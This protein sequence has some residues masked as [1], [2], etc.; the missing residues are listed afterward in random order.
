[1]SQPLSNFLSV[2]KNC[3]GKST[4]EIIHL[5]NGIRF[6][7]HNCGKTEETIFNNVEKSQLQEAFPGVPIIEGI[8]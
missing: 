5:P 8:N 2:C 3:Q 7:C 1:M 6:V 4:V